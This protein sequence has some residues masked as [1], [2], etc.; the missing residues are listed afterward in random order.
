MRNDNQILDEFGSSD[1]DPLRG[2]SVQ[3][4]DHRRWSRMQRRQAGYLS[5]CFALY[6]D[7]SAGEL[8]SWVDDGGAAVWYSP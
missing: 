1:N 7:T 3:D 2:Q 5:Y 6:E 8:A 4:H